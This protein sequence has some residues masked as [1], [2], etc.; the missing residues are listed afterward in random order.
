MEAPLFDES[1]M[2]EC[3]C[4]CSFLRIQQLDYG[5]EVVFSHYVSSFGSEQ[6]NAW[7]RFKENVKLIWCIITGKR[8]T[9][10][11]I[12]VADK[13]S[14]KEFKDMVEKIDLSNM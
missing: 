10:F 13:K 7:E 5:G 12:V 8:Y 4:G 14:A 3:D 9:F 6:S 11:E 2:L 1:L